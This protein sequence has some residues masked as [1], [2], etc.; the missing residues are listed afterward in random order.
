MGFRNL[1]AFNLAMLAKE[2]W[3]LLTRLDS[4]I[5]RIY[6]ARYFLFSDFLNAQLGCNP[7]YAWWS[8]HSSLEVI[9][10]GQKVVSWKW[11]NNPH[12]GG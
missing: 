8:I 9:Q 6:K 11:Q 3:R 7:S 10:E 5:S 12:F 1:H 2:G 4:L